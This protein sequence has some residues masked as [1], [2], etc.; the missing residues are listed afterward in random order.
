M[1]S[2]PGSLVRGRSL[3]LPEAYPTAHSIS[4]FFSGISNQAILQI[5][6]PPYLASF[7]AYTLFQLK[8]RFELE[9]SIPPFSVTFPHFGDR[10]LPN[11]ENPRPKIQAWDSLKRPKIDKRETPDT[12]NLLRSPLAKKTFKKKKK[13][14]MVKSIPFKTN[15]GKYQT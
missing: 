2:R 8:P 7:P 15:R 6:H 11:A 3:R 14:R 13:K 4:I 5:R 9:Q 10:L 12:S 1:E